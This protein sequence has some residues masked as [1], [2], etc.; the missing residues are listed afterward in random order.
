MSEQLNELG[1]IDMALSA[2]EIDDLVSQ[3]R[4]RTSDRRLSHQQIQ[5]FFR[6]LPRITEA[7]LTADGKHDAAC[8]ICFNAFVAVLAEEETARAMDSPARPAEELGV[9]RLQK[10]CGHMFCRK[11]I[12]RWIS[13]GH[14]SCPNCRR[15]LLPDAERRESEPRPTASDWFLAR[16]ADSGISVRGLN[17]NQSR[18][19]TGPPE[20]LY[21]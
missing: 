21:S 5:K 12:M 8:P 9:T 13:E 11:D 7:E 14:A 15:P 17:I 6:E 18:R 16:I 10:T 2:E 1:P 19:Q 4:L 3:F 20:G